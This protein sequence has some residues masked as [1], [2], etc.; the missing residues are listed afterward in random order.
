MPALSVVAHDIKPCIKTAWLI[1]HGA[2]P[3]NYTN[4][5][6]L[7]LQQVVQFAAAAMF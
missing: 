5:L 6:G 1:E 4:T 2:A 7:V 3:H